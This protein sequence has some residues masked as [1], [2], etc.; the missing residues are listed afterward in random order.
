MHVTAGR[1]QNTKSCCCPSRSE[2]HK[3]M[4]LH[5]QSLVLTPSLRLQAGSFALDCT[6]TVSSPCRKSSRTLN[7]GVRSPRRSP[8]KSPLKRAAIPASDRF[9]PNRQASWLHV[10]TV[11]PDAR[12]AAVSDVPDLAAACGVRTRI[13]EFQPAPP[14][15]QAVPDLRTQYSRPKQATTGEKRRISTVPERVL[16]APGMVDDYY[17]NLLDW[18]AAN[19]VGVALDRAVY[20]WN[21]T[22]GAVSRVLETREGTYGSSLKWSPDGYLAFGTSEGDVEIWDAERCTKLRTMSGHTGRVGA[23]SWNGVVVSSACK[24]GSIWHHDVRIQQHKV[25]EL[26][27]HQAEVCGLVWRPDGTQLAS[28]GNDNLVTIWDA[29]STMPRYTK[30]AHQA[31]VKALAWCPWQNNLLATGGGSLDRKIHFWNTSTGIR[32]N[33]ISTDSQ[34]TALYFSPHVRELVSCHGYP[35]NLF[36]LW[37][38]P[39]Q[40]RI[41]DVEAHDS[42]IL[43]AALSPDGQS[44]ATCA[45]DENLKFWHIWDAA[46]KYSQDA[47]ASKL[48]IR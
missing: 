46:R 39:S 48:V 32:S 28:G 47:Q 17:L 33:T 41:A 9:I 44:L 6:S 25:S 19:T 37:S 27:N 21:A 14:Q 38:L 43:H 34:V 16:D 12:A 35:G 31:A 11:G 30:T 13:L 10:Q 40:T 22:T 7:S 42:R 20:A 4:A 23:L 15:I 5:N 45:A 36:T 18:S 29:R 1:K 26:H 8:R 24:D 2:E 3:N